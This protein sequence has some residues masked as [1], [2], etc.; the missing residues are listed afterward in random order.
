RAAHELHAEADPPF[1]DLDAVH[2]DDVGMPDAR[3][4]APFAGDARRLRIVMEIVEAE[5][6]ERHLAFEMTIPRAIDLA[7]RA[8]AEP[9]DPRQL[10]PA[11]DRRAAGPPIAGVRSRV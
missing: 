6:L 4:Q 1:V 2:G 11:A 7:E 10:R 8:A 3:Q 9:L 5:Q